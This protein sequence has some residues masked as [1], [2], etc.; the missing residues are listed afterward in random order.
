M[1]KIFIVL[2]ISLF[3][4]ASAGFISA[5]DSSD[6]SETIDI[7]VKIVWNDEDSLSDRPSE[8]TV[9]LVKDGNIVDTVKLNEENSWNFTFEDMDADGSYSI[10]ES[11]ISDY[12]VKTVGDVENGFV[13]TYSIAKEILK[14]GEDDAVE[15]A[16][17]EDNL[18]DDDVET[19]LEEDNT[20]ENTNDDENST[21]NETETTVN[22][23]QT[24]NDTSE[25]QTD[26]NSS[27]K[28]QTDKSKPAKKD[29]KIKTTTKI[30]Y[31]ATEKQTPKEPV[32]TN[33]T[34]PLDAKTGLPIA[35][36]VLVAIVIAIVPF[37]RRK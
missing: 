23:N 17:S 11:D 37:N 10:I 13:I 8:V 15:T 5:A 19:P 3:L 7:P 22:T 20:T 30:T 9:T 26:N 34:T 36:L 18:S 14:A 2:L 25:K 29:T 24:D 35:V 6:D 21:V 1:K 28:N 4:I 12:S 16:P 27:K 33:E 31:K 32:K